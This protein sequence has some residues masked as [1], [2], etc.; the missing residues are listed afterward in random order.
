MSDENPSGSKMFIPEPAPELGPGFLSSYWTA[1]E[2]LPRMSRSELFRH[3]IARGIENVLAI[4]LSS[5]I[6]VGT[7]SVALFLLGGFMLFLQNVDSALTNSG[8]QFQL[9]AYLR[10][11]VEPEAIDAFLETLKSNS[12]VEQ[13][14]HV[15][16]EQALEEFRLQLGANAE[17]LA[18]LSVTNPLPASVEISVRGADSIGQ[19][20]TDELVNKLRNSEIIDE[21]TYA[22]EWVEQSKKII[23]VFRL[24]GIT[25]LGLVML[26]VVFLISNTIKLVIYMR[27]HEISIMLLVG[28]GD[29]AIRV[30]FMLGGLIQGV[31][32]SILGLGFLRLTYL[33]IEAQLRASPIIGKALPDIFFLSRIS[34]VSILFIGAGVGCLGSLF[35]LRKFMKV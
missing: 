19:A 13:V 12:T 4:P 6:T 26:I 35:A 27:R 3:F 31:V 20:A 17:L 16:K 29:D 15:T 7:I 34:V 22:S 24:I 32:G 23:K 33:L 10:D 28:A 21:V 30:P 8:A 25:A 9:L 1:E 11:D 14:R 18:G 5:G 2:E